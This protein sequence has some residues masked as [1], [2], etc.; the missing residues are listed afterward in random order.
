MDR[1]KNP[2][3]PNAGAV[4][5]ALIGRESQIGNFH[6]LLRRLSSG[7]SDQSMIV[8]G[9]RGVGKT[10]LLNEFRAIASRENW[11]VVEFEASKHDDAHFRQVLFTQIAPTR[12]ELIAMGL[13]YTPS[14]GYA[15]FTVPDFD[16]FMVRAVPV[17]EVPPIQSRNGQRVP[18]S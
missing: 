16:K 15:A 8:R 13:L 1:V 11:E 9:L 12:A 14:H 3:T 2:Y 10:V 5:E 18:R 17:L 6:L 7:R 4:P